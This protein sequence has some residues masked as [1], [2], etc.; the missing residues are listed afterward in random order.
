MQNI[1]G[2]SGPDGSVDVFGVRLVGVNAENGRKLLLTI[3]F[4]AMA[5][6]LSAALRWLASAILKRRSENAEF[7]S[8]QAIHLLSAI[9]VIIGVASIWFDNPA[10]LASVFALV[11]AGLAFALQRVVTAIA[12]YFVLL[13]GKNFSIGDRITMGGVRGDVIDL[14]FIQTTIMEMGQAPGEQEA[15]PAMW[16]KSRQYTGRIVT[17]SNALIF[18]EPVYNYTKDFPYLWEEIS[19]PIR[20]DAD[21]QRAE[22]I[23]LHAAETHTVH[24]ESMGEEAIGEMKR[25]YFID[26]PD[27]GPRVYYRLT[28]NWIEL[29]VRFICKDHDIRELK[30]RMSRDILAGLEE[31]G[32]EVASATFEIVG[33]PEVKVALRENSGTR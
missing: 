15:D 24:I 23:L 25:R 2:I 28:D 4:I 5:V 20:Y 18:D 14:G 7:W 10:R 11:T 19:L 29:T 33:A 27:M 21:R 6:F 30:D 1:I 31:A 13:R 16:V 22:Q 3:V 17:V 9:V 12:G 8:R 32:I 26:E